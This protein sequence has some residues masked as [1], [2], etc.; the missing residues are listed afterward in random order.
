MKQQI[1]LALPPL[2]PGE[3]PPTE[4][5]CCGASAIEQPEWY[6]GSLVSYECGDAPHHR[7]EYIW[8]KER[9]SWEPLHDCPNPR[10]SAVLRALVCGMTDRQREA[11]AFT[12]A[13]YGNLS[14]ED[15][16]DAA[17]NALEVKR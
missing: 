7:S 2:E 1:T 17:G 11:V 9:K 16:I 10:P 14:A 6:V 15:C 8:G 5:P 3:E 12:E 13:C 4:C